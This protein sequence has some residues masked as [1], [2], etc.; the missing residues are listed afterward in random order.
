[1][2]LAIVTRVL[3]AHQGLVELTDRPGGGAEFR[4]LL[5]AT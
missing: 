2:G 4:I 1:M 3:D 5:P